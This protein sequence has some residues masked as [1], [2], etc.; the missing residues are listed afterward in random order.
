MFELVVLVTLIIAV[1]SLLLLTLFN[2]LLLC[3][4]AVG[5]VS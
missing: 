2:M 4:P 1:C 3:E 5:N